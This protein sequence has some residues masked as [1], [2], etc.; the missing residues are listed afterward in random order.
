MACVVIGVMCDCNGAAPI[1]HHAR[2]E[3]CHA[4]FRGGFVFGRGGLLL[5]R[6]GLR[7]LEQLITTTIPRCSSVFMRVAG[8]VDSLCR[9]ARQGGL[10]PEML[11][12]LQ[13]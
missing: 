9:R 3:D 5:C 4:A 1:Y 2:G 7:V 10:S 11:S 13:S 8:G 12:R 6:L